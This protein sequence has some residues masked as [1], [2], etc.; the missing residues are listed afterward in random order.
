[1][2][3]LN[4]TQA[5]LKEDFFSLQAKLLPGISADQLSLLDDR[6]QPILTPV[7]LWNPEE[8]TPGASVKY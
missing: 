8:G 6:K 1:M 4:K 7:L 5:E 3:N 2:A